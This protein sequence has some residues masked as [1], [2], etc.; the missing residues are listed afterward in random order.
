[1]KPLALLP[2]DDAPAN[3][4]AALPRWPEGVNA[5]L[6]L[7]P[8]PE[9]EIIDDVVEGWDKAWDSAVRWHD[10]KYGDL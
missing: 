2:L 3:P 8:L 9:V 7:T 4:V 6:P 5:L 1:M 10:S